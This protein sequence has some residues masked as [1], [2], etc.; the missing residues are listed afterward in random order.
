M[1]VLGDGDVGEGGGAVEGKEREDAADARG[2]A[3]RAAV[4]SEHNVDRWLVAGEEAGPE[5]GE[6]SAGG[7]DAAGGLCLERGEG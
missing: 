5:A 4:T 6:A 1:E 7:A 3:A 2:D